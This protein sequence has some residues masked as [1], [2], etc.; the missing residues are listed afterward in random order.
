MPI[1]RTI[2][3]NSSLTTLSSSLS[4]HGLLVW[5]L[6]FSSTN[7]F[8]IQVRAWI[9]IVHCVLLEVVLHQERHTFWAT[10]VLKDKTTSQTRFLLLTAWGFLSGSYHILLSLWL[11]PSWLDSSRCTC[12]HNLLPSCSQHTSIWLVSSAKVEF[13]TSSPMSWQLVGGW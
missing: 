4:F 3:T 12:A 2:L 13:F 10:V 9:N 5:M 8:S 11:L 1:S 7:T 6:V